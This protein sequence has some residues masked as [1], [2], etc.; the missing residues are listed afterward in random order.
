MQLR[1]CCLVPVLAATESDLSGSTAVMNREDFM[2]I[3]NA[4]SVSRRDLLVRR[5][6]ALGL[7]LDVIESC[8][9]E[10]SEGIKRRCIR[11]D[12]PR[13]CEEDLCRDPNN[14]VWESYCPNAAKL[15]ALN[16]LLTR[17]VVM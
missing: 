16:R 4:R 17:A 5:V 1:G 15:I 8:G 11:C 6:T 14:P 13:A 7:D 3:V 2:Q 9:R 10:W 12:F